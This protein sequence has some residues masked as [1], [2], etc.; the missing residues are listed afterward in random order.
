M[1]KAPK[2][3]LGEAAGWKGELREALIRLGANELCCS[4]RLSLQLSFTHSRAWGTHSCVRETLPLP[5]PCRS[6]GILVPGWPN[7]RAG[8][9]ISSLGGFKNRGCGAG[10]QELVVT[11][12]VEGWTR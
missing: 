5:S 12:V 10:G 8:V 1:T 2:N 3:S 11:V 4:P 9:G 7:P 6:R